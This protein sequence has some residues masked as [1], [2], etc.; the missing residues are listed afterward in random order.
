MWSLNG[1]MWSPNG[2]MW[3]PKGKLWCPNEKCQVQTLNL[4]LR[5]RFKLRTQF[6]GA[7]RPH[8]ELRPQFTHLTCSFP[9]NTR[10]E[11]DKTLFS[12][13]KPQRPGYTVITVAFRWEITNFRKG[14]IRS[15]QWRQFTFLGGQFFN[16]EGI[17]ILSV[18]AFSSVKADEY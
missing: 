6:S 14:L 8:Y 13:P 10:A 17:W 9:L 12:L 1:K 5:P 16:D 7:P 15:N 4:G 2:K 18:K 3:N 11:L